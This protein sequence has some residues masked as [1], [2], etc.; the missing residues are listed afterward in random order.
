MLKISANFPWRGGIIAPP[1]I[2][3]IK[4]AEPWEVY[5]PSPEIL[6][7][8]IHGHMIEQ[9][10]PPESK[11]Y[12]ANW[13]DVKT[14]I[15]IPIIPSVLNIFSVAIGLSFARKNPPI[16]IATQTPNNKI[17]SKESYLNGDL[18]LWQLK[19]L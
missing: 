4:N 11:A 9:N 7:V 3:I 16:C 1:K 12:K 13:P 15:I 17:S 19:N 18:Q 14:P 8:K 2:I 5:F 6:N 10:K